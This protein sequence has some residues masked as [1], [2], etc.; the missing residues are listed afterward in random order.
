MVGEWGELAILLQFH[1]NRP[2]ILPMRQIPLPLHDDSDQ[3]EL[4][5]TAC[6]QYAF[7]RISNLEDDVKNRLILM[8]E[9]HS[10]KELMGRF[11][12][13]AKKGIFVPD[14]DQM[15]DEDLFF[16]WNQAHDEG[17]SLLM[18]A[19][20]EPS[21]WAISL[22]DLQS[23]VASMELLRILP[24]DDELIAE[25]INQRLRCQDA[26]IS[27]KALEYSLK[28]IERD[29]ASVN[30]FIDHC[31]IK[32]KENNRIIKIEDVKPLLFAPRQTNLL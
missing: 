30:I 32:A 12:V 29:Y 26:A 21:Q 20:K 5:I 7:N 24:P 25:L 10:G 22:P 3:N 18:S 23:R 16:I 2:I 8:G 28:R 6:N 27:S 4:I 19:T 17:R 31:I 13:Q 15:S 1:G 11:F 14:A 9:R